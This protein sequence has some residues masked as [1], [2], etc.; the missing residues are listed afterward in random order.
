METATLLGHILESAAHIEQW[1]SFR[2]NIVVS[3]DRNDIDKSIE[4]LHDA[5]RVF[6]AQIHDNDDITNNAF[7]RMDCLSLYRL[8]EAVTSL[9]MFIDIKNGGDW[10]FFNCDSI[11]YIKSQLPKRA[12]VGVFN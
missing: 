3:I 10:V 4:K 8:S 9:W 12:L 7:A 1:L 2:F 6:K 5:I 11:A